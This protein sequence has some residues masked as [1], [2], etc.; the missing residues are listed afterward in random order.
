MNR[1][2]WNLWNEIYAHYFMFTEWERLIKKINKKREFSL[3]NISIF[4]HF[5][6]SIFQCS[7]IENWC[8]NKKKHFSTGVKNPW[9]KPTEKKH[10][11]KKTRFL[12]KT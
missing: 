11:D 3:R 12:L 8:G 9:K 2:K 4:Q 7:K 6:V 1:I 5:N 10:S